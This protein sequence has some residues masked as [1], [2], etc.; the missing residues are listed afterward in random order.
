M[1]IPQKNLVVSGDVKPMIPEKISQI[2]SVIAQEKARTDGDRDFNYWMLEKAVQVHHLVALPRGQEFDALSKFV[3]A[4]IDALPDCLEHFH[5]VAEQAN[6]SP[7]TDLFLNLATDFVLA[8]P[9]ELELEVGFGHLMDEAFMAHRLLEELN[10]RCLHYLGGPGLPVDNSFANVIVHGLIGDEFANDLDLAVHFAIESQ[11]A[12]E[13]AVTANLH[14]KPLQ[15][16]ADAAKDWP[17]LGEELMVG[18]RF[19]F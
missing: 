11:A 17:T 4:Y 16:V 19:Q 2:R 1:A 14:A 7:Y 10:D 18:I 6:L 13:R 5:R 12:Q 15:A 8:P 9:A 3:V